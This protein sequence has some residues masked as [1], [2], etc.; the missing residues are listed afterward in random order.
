MASWRPAVLV[1]VFRTHILTGDFCFSLF[2]HDRLTYVEKPNSW[3]FAVGIGAGARAGCFRCGLYGRV[4]IDRLHGQR[5]PYT[6]NLVNLVVAKQLGKITMDE[7]KR[8]LAPR[9]VAYVKQDDQW[10]ATVKPW[11]QEI[12][13][14]THYLHGADGNPVAQD[15]V[16]GP[17]EHYQWISEPLWLRSHESDSSVKTLV[18]AR[19]RLFYIADEAPTSLVGDHALPDKWFLTARDAF[20]GL[21][22][23][24]VVCL[25]CFPC[26]WS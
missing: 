19:G 1:P 16:V 3:W 20:N 8:V 17:P 14:W 4:S 13:E 2:H 25:D 22:L 24:D 11:P 21:L 26:P 23:W 7:V 10:T 6:D 15:T 18:T 5:L 9:G 12:D